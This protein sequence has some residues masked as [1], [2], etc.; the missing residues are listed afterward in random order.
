MRVFVTG[1]TGFIG[2]HLV[3]TLLARGDRCIVIS[4]SGRD[5]WND[6]GVRVIAGDP[7]Q[8]GP[9]QQEVAS[10][11]AVVNLVGARIVDP[12]HRWTTARKALLRASRVDTTRHVVEAIRSAASPPHFVS[13]S[14]I[15][16]Y[17]PRGSDIVTENDP[18]GTDF[19]ATLAAEWERTAREAETCT[20]VTLV[21]GGLALG[22]GGG[23]LDSLVPL[24]KLGL[25]GPWGNGEQ[26]WSWI[27][28]DDQVRLILFAINRTLT[29]PLNATAPN[30]ITVNA[31]A[32]A[33]GKAL[34]RPAFARAPAFALRL[35]L[36]EA[37]DALIDLQRVVPRRAEAAGFEF[38]FPTVETA[39]E[40]IFS[41]G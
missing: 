13:A 7:T 21:R 18:P 9:W 16:Y 23:V 8:P 1:G 12:P 10:C 38:R 40:E 25:G 41:A 24:F 17:G 39:L 33:L 20:G 4:R 19:L 28:L 11:D 36:G 14:A 32:S 26:W 5:P 30:P 3:R 15:G 37:A 29:G 2:S 34:G 27:H 31:F 6:A 22:T 35:A